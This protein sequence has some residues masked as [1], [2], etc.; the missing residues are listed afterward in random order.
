MNSKI[1]NVIGLGYIG[2]PT[3]ALLAS[4]N[5][6][7]NGIDIDKNIV[8]KINKGKAHIN[9][10]GLSSIVNKAVN[11]GNLKAFNKVVTGDIFIICVPTPIYLGK[12]PTPNVEHVLNAAR[13]IAPLIKP[14]DYVILEST[15]PVGTTE[16][17]S[18]V[19][20]EGG[21]NIKKIFIAYCPERVL[22]GSILNELVQ[23]DR[24]V[25]GLNAEGTKKIANFYRS[26]I[27]GKVHETNAKT[28]EMTKLVENSFRDVN[29]AFANEL[30]LLCSNKKINVS[31]VISLANKH[32]RVNILTPGIG[33]GGH[34][35]AVDPWFLVAC[36]K[37]NSNLIRIGRH[38][39]DKKTKWVINKIR[40][41][42]KILEN[43]KKRKIKIAC[44]GLSYK[45]NTEDI[46]NS[47]AKKISE[48]LVKSGYKVLVVEPNIKNFFFLKLTDLDTAIR[49]ADI[50]AILV[51]HKEFI[52]PNI[53]KKLINSNYLDFCDAL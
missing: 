9:E 20:K 29:I 40:L 17:L 7:V 19:F 23:N 49:K 26:F 24:I 35:I 52:K 51:K 53:K 34:C 38:I 11:K 13:N 16:K 50:I 36:D 5:F 18:K 42:A 32:P 30:S 1:I 46:R 3:A 25:G 4:K 45:P 10:P 27:K 15:S 28:A 6:H 37:S 41:A 8:R 31:D 43:K 33:V 22:P 48:S 47:P 14:G 44:L 2:L 21:V 12:P 39:N